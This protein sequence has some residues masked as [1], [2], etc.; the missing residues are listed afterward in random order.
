M[1][2][3]K[4]FLVTQY[5]DFID[6]YHKIQAAE[7]DLKHF[8]YG[9]HP[10][11]LKNPLWKIYQEYLKQS[12]DSLANLGNEFLNMIWELEA[13]HEVYSKHHDNVLKL[14]LIFHFIRKVSTLSLN[15]PSV[16]RDRLIYSSANICHQFN[17][18]V[19]EAWGEENLPKYTHFIKLEHVQCPE[20]R[21]QSIWL[22]FKIGRVNSRAYKKATSNFR[23]FYQHRLPPNIAM[24]TVTLIDRKIKQNPDKGAGKKNVEMVYTME[25][26]DHFDLKECAQLLRVEYQAAF[27]AFEAFQ[28]LIHAQLSHAHL[29]VSEQNGGHQ[30][31]IVSV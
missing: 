12:S 3:N 4:K 14:E 29:I 30:P 31:G 26:V 7:T 19:G 24:G 13:W 6:E 22:K 28:E 21:K 18:K 8:P 17:M 2:D 11:V 10:H 23:N 20:L 16:M 15:L 25:L 1:T 9:W 5:S 27:L